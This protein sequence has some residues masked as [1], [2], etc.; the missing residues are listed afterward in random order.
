[1][2]DLTADF[3]THYIEG[4]VPH[5]ERSGLDPNLRVELISHV[6]GN[7]WQGGCRDG[8]TLPSDFQR[9]LS[10]YKWEEYILPPGCERVTVTMYDAA[11]EPDL[12]EIAE[13]AALVNGWLDKGYKTLVHCQAGLNRSGLLAAAT[14]MQRGTHNADEAIKL[15]REKRCD[16]VLCNRSFDEW[17]RGLPE[18]ALV[19]E[20][21]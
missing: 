15:L 1:M 10:L 9:V 19:N 4:F 20:A 6:D 3:E 21:S 11:E 12:R 13:L 18:M 7:L 2:P 14:L 8:V 5:A 16:L 17:L